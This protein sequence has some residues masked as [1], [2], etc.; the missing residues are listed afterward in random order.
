MIDDLLE[1]S[2]IDQGNESLEPVD[3]NVVL[4]QVRQNLAASISE[5]RAVVSNDSLPTVVANDSQMVQ[6]LQ[7]LVA[8]AIKFHAPDTPRVPHLR[9]RARGGVAILGQRQRHRHRP[10]V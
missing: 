1:L 9:R 6:L 2:K 3:M 7:N 8:N 4:D 10:A 5:S